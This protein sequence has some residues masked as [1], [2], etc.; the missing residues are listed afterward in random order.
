MRGPTRTAELLAVLCRHEVDFIVVGMMAAVLQGT[1]ALTFD[2]DV[3][4]SRESLNVSRLLAALREI[5]AVFRT[6]PRRIVPAESHLVT[7]GHKLL[8]TTLGHFDALGAI[9]EDAGYD[10]LLGDTL[11][12][13]VG[14]LQVRVLSLARLIEVKERAGRPKD[15]AVL[16]LLRATLARSHRG[17]GSQ[18]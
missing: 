9:A 8:D 11:V 4:Y 16:P 18:T 2:L 6:D 12:L 7:K 10:E 13:S 17:E 5:D 15:L 1:P 14:G 3:V